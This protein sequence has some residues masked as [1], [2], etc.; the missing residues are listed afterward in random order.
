MTNHYV[1]DNTQKDSPQIKAWQ[2]VV[3]TFNILSKNG[4]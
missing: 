2:A 1:A 4:K 3:L